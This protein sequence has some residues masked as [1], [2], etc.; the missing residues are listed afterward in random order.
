MGG[1]VAEL[2]ADWYDD[3]TSEPAVNPTGPA[4]EYF[5][6]TRGG[7]WYFNASRSR[8]ADR[9]KRPPTYRSED[10]GLRLALPVAQP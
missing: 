8:V 3:Y 1:N 9:T 10:L 2:C 6:V 4:T 5:R 7:S